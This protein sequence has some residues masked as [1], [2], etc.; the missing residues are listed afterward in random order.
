MAS[1]SELKGS[2]FGLTGSVASGKDTAAEYFVSAHGF[3]M[4]L[5]V[6]L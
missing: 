1:S 5:Q 3:F 6:I 4:C 2:V